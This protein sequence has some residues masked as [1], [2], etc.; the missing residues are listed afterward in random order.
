LREK[1]VEIAILVIALAVVARAVWQLLGPLLPSL[2]IFLLVG[3]LVLFV[4]RGPR[5]GTFPK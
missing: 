1:L 3:W 2:L 4:V 5:G